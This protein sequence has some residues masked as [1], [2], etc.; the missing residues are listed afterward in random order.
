MLSYQETGSPVH[1]LTGATK[2]IFFLLWAGTTMVTY[3]T[4]CL[5][6][7]FL[8]AMAAFRLSRIRFR[9]V[10]FVVY[11]IA[12]FL[13]LNNVAIYL[14]SPEEGVR[15]YGTRHEWFRI[16]GPYTVTAEQLF[17][18]ANVILKYATVTPMAILFLVTT[19]PSEFASSLNRIGV[20]Y[21]V[22]YA[23]AIAMRYIPDVQRDF[24]HIA[25]AQQARGVDLSRKER[26]HK[27]IKNVFAVLIPLMLSSLERIETVSAALELRGFGRG[28][29]R[30]W[31]AARPFGKGDRAALALIVVVAATVTVVTFLDGERFYWFGDGDGG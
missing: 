26:L 28:R 29:S 21:R 27:R 9:D 15:I 24:Q 31:Y 10:S 12:A 16:A 2:L 17:Y 19:Q 1:R 6:A 7:M 3:D 4:R 14:F 13:L 23:V 30:T 11:L 22:A 18:Q 25:F 5:A 8:L 20:G